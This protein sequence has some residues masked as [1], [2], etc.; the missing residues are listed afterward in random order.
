MDFVDLLFA[1]ARSLLFAM[2]GVLPIINP[3]AS[4]PVFV[5]LTR[6]LDEP[7][8]E[9]LARRVGK[10]AALLLAAA[11]V[12]GSFV[13]DLF[14]ISLPVV[15]VAGGVIVAY[16]AWLLLNAQPPGEDDKAQM[17]QTF[18]A[19]NVE[20]NSFYPMTFPLTCGPGALAA[21][22]AVGA[23][24]KTRQVTL[25]VANLAGGLVAML[26]IGVLIALLFRYAPRLVRRLGEVGQIVFLRIM[27]FMVLCVG[28]QIIWEGVRALLLSVL[29]AAAA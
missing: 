11:M 22:I 28:V 1:F 12:L 26:L 27:S 7:T 3:V 15:R 18:T 23:S 25:A 9:Q 20:R 2:A 19:A 14:G 13:L 6:A 5:S 16:N 24:L 10:N 17:A 21:A 29:P 8:R 4:A